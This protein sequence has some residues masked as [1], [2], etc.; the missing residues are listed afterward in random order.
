MCTSNRD[1]RKL[2]NNQF[3]Q[4][5]VNQSWFKH[6][7]ELHKKWT[8][9]GVSA[10]RVTTL[11]HLQ[12]KSYQPL[13][14]Q[15]HHQ[16]HL[17]WAKEKKNWTVAQRSKALCSDKSTFC[18]S[19]GNQGP[20]VW[21][22]RGDTESMLLEVQCD[23]STVSDGLGCHVICWCCSTVFSEVH[24]QRRHLPGY[25]RALNASFCWQ[26]LLRCWFHFPAGLGTCPHCQRYQK[27]VQCTV[28]LFLIGQQTCLTWIKAWNMSLCEMNLYNVWVSLCE[29]T[30]KKYWHF[31]WYSFFFWCICMCT[32]WKKMSSIKTVGGKAHFL[33]T[34][35]TWT[36]LFVKN[37]VLFL[38]NKQYSCLNFACQC[39]VTEPGYTGHFFM[40]WLH[41]GSWF[42][43]HTLGL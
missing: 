19:F 28:L 26:A 20:R 11:R 38:Q 36:N 6:L 21:R 39:D 37:N 2:E 1:D 13:L 18:I 43:R 9:A 32:S 40:S 15:K 27:L 7:G 22:K 33:L 16:K 8:E 4:K 34:K 31:S 30:D 3:N 25:F 41:L 24:S 29:M 14:K 10:S 12:E 35:N 17:T 23:V 42:S 5:L